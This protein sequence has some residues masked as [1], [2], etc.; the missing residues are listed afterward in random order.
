L[1]GRSQRLALRG[2]PL[3]SAN[4]LHTADNTPECGESLAIRIPLS[5]EVQLR[6][7]ADTDEEVRSRGIRRVARHGNGTVPMADFGHIRPLQH[8]LQEDLLL[9]VRV[10]TPLDHL[11]LHSVV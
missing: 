8:Y 3:Y 10:R 1:D 11:D 2:G 5:A 9:S 7:V 4:D 6:L